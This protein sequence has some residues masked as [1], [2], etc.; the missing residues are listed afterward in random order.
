VAKQSK[1]QVIGRRWKYAPPPWRMFE[2]LTDEMDRWLPRLLANETRPKATRGTTRPS[3]VVFRPWVDPMIREVV[4]EM[5][6]DES[7]GSV[8]RVLATASVHLLSDEERRR[9]R[10]RL[11][12]VF[13]GALRDWVDEPHW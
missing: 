7:S 4:V 12:T 5:T 10:Y 3:L 9:V 2:A 11:G 8:L 13:G 1:G 6:T